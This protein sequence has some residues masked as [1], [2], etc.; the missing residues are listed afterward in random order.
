MRIKEMIT[1][2]RIVCMV[3]QNL[4]DGTRRNVLKTVRRIYMLRYQ[5]ICFIYSPAPK[6]KKRKLASVSVKCN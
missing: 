5:E 1:K 4:L 3:K 6:K 2:D